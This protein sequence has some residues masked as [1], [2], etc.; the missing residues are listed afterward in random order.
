MTLRFRTVTT[1]QG[2]AGFVA[3]NRGLC[4]VYLPSRTVGSLRRIIKKD[5]PE[6]TEDQRLLPDFANALKRYFAGKAVNFTVQIDR[7]GLSPFEVDVYRA[8]RRIAYAKTRSYKQLAEA[9]GRPNA[10]RAVG[11][12]LSRNPYPIVIPCHRVVKS[13]GSPGG[14]SAPG[15]TTTKHRLLQMEAD[16]PIT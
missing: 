10:A 11:T 14:F 9:I 5:S 2:H 1:I 7:T 8:C 13:D 4:R 15:G 3:S 12:A 16:A 6:A